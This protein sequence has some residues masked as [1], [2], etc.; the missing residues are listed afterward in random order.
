MF[1]ISRQIKEPNPNG[2]MYFSSLTEREKPKC[3]N[4]ALC[5]LLSRQFGIVY[6]SYAD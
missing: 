6:F 1:D 4:I 2:N 3:K 5:R